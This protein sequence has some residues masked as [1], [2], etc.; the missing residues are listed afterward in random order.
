MKYLNIIIL[1]LIV[2][3]TLLVGCRKVEPESEV[4]SNSSPEWIA[5]SDGTYYKIFTIDG[6]EY[7]NFYVGSGLSTI[8]HKGNC[9]N[10]IHIYKMENK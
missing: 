1:F 3:L 4:E 2:Q 8:V 9:T 10:S 7:F 5:A 6:C